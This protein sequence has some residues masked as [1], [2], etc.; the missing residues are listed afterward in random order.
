MLQHQMRVINKIIIHCSDSPDHLE[1]DSN[2]I[3]KWHIERGFRAIGYHA[4][5]LRDGM[6]EI[7]RDE[8]EVGAHAK[9]YNAKSLG[10][11]LVGRNDFTD[12]QIKALIQLVQTWRKKYGISTED[13]IGHYEVNK[14]KT[15]PNINMAVF[16]AVLS[17]D[18]RC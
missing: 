5:I 14:H 8:H 11:C 9:G 1:I 16:R 6:V 7:G 4:V 18:K 13:V 12:N 17:V 10:I 2:T 15:C 3:E